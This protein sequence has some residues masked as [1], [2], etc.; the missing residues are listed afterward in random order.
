MR[1][2]DTI[3]G[4]ALALFALWVIWESR[5]YPLGTLWE[6]GPAYMPILLATCLMIFA[7]IVAV[8]GDRSKRFLAI[9]WIEWRHAV[10]I[11]AA[12]IFGAAALERLGYRA[13]ILV[14][15]IVLL[16]FVE[17]KGWVMTTAF[18]AALS[19]SSYFLF[20]T[21]LRVP[22]PSGPFGW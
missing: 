4:G 2:A 22:L 20:H 14:L 3:S 21:V 19:F 8:W 1:R 16:K 11:L 9:D 18:A 13:T 5:E 7:L 10:A 17:R 6:P 12:C 15:L